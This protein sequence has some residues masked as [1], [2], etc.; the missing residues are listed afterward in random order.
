MRMLPGDLEA[1]LEE[2][3]FQTMHGDGRT[4]GAPNIEHRIAV[5]EKVLGVA[6]DTPEPGRPR[7]GYAQGSQE[8]AREINHYGR[9][10]VRFH[11][12]IRRARDR[13]AGRQHGVDEH[14]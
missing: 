6:A 12:H 7:Y 13:H 5:E 8:D 10:L 2:G 4:G 11:G 1:W 9:W 14:S 3:R